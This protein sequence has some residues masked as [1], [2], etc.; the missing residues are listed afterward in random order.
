MANPTTTP[1]TNTDDFATQ[2]AKAL[3]AVAGGIG[4][5]AL[6]NSQ[7]NPLQQAVGKTLAT[8]IRDAINAGTFVRAADRR[9]AEAA[10]PATPEAVRLEAFGKKFVDNKSKPSGKKTWTNDQYMFAQLSAF[11]LSDGTT[12]GELRIRAVKAKDAHDRMLPISQRLAGVLEM[13]KADP[14]GEEYKSEDY[15]F[16]EVGNRSPTSNARGRP[17]C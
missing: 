15:V 12:R 5:G 1:T 4:G 9:K 16:G 10:T 6:A 8:N 3:A 7:G 17:R 2:L 13:A 11:T 14:A